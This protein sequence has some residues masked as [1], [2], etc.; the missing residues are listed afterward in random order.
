MSFSWT[1]TE[2]AEHMKLKTNR[3]IASLD[4]LLG[5]LG[6]NQ[7]P[8]KAQHA[9]GS[10][11]EAVTVYPLRGLGRHDAELAQEHLSF[12]IMMDLG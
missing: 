11:K 6:T 8:R 4:G 12:S 7:I 1:V 10:V 3:A 5:V 2:G 9:N